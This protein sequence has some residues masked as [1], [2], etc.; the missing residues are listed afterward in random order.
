MLNHRL[1][2]HLIALTLILKGPWDTERAWVMKFLQMIWR[3]C[4]VTIW[5]HA[6]VIYVLIW[7]FQ[8]LRIRW[9]CWYL[10]RHH[11]WRRIR[12]VGW[13]ELAYRSDLFLFQLSKSIK[14]M[15]FIDSLGADRRNLVFLDDV[16]IIIEHVYVRGPIKQIRVNLEVY[17][18][19]TKFLGDSLRL[20]NRWFF[21][22]IL[23]GINIIFE[24]FFILDSTLLTLIRFLRLHMAPIRLNCAYLWIPSSTLIISVRLCV[25][26]GISGF[27]WCEAHLL[28]EALLLWHQ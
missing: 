18:L 7:T 11:T 27:Y 12:P 19:V 13:L 2:K 25:L 26:A 9:R 15:I 24:W 4:M 21:T 16:R 10:L 3:L 17:S 5:I 14:P 20:S 1:C 28:P 23:E 22:L 6:N 8:W